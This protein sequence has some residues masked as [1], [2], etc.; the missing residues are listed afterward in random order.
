LEQLH[1]SPLRVSESTFGQA[2]NRCFDLSMGIGERE[3]IQFEQI[4]ASLQQADILVRP[5][6]DWNEAIRLSRGYHGPGGDPQKENC[7]EADASQ[8]R[9][10]KRGIPGS[11]SKYAETLSKAPT[12]RV[13][14]PAPGLQPSLQGPNPCFAL[15]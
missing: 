4:S 13:C 11:P 15:A 2:P 3:R 6:L 10:C 14:V 12:P 9:Q 1:P 8:H 7:D 5:I